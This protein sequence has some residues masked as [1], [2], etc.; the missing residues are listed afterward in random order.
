M[1][2]LYDISHLEH[3]FEDLK[4]HALCCFQA[5]ASLAPELVGVEALPLELLRRLNEAIES[6]ESRYGAVNRRIYMYIIF[7]IICNIYDMYYI[8]IFLKIYIILYLIMCAAKQGLCIHEARV[9]SRSYFSLCPSL[10]ASTPR[11]R[12]L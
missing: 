5:V 6:F 11:L 10:G 9:A 4:A 1:Y 7:D 2:Y 3:R 8:H 12:W